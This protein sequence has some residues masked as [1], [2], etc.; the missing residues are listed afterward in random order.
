M[1]ESKRFNVYRESGDIGKKLVE[2]TFCGE[3]RDVERCEVR[4]PV[5]EA[6]NERDGFIRDCDRE[7]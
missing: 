1:E 3:A 6:R 7:S 5:E 4:E 2:V